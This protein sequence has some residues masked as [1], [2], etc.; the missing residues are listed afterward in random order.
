MFYKFNDVKV[1]Y[2]FVG[3]EKANFTTILLH[4]WGCSGDIFDNLVSLMPEK[5]FLIVD[6]PPFGQSDIEPKG[7]NIFTY[8]N[9]I[10]SLVH[11]CGL[12][13][14][15]VCGH[16]FGGRV[17]ILLASLNPQMVDR[18]VLLDSAGLKPRRKIGYYFKL[19]Y[20]KIAKSMG[21]MFS[22]AGSDDYKALSDDMKRVFVAV[23]NE[24]LDDYLPLI[25][26]KTLIIFGE[27]DS[28]TP[29]YMAKRLHKNIKN[30]RLEI[31]K[32]AGHFCFVD[33]LMTCYRLVDEFLEG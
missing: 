30:S 2:R 23:V 24:Y 26:Q 13:H 5:R 33:N 15:N 27:K 14:V 25:R 12:T 8:A 9:M 6:F 4:G 21:F 7:W 19:Y 3:N 16:S 11:H 18:L 28:Q 31:L 17:A 29:I 1:A 20:Y 22:N 10:T 32:G